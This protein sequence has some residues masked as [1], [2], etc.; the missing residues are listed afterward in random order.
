MV[1]QQYYNVA[2]CV[3]LAGADQEEDLVRCYFIRSDVRETAENIIKMYKDILQE[4]NN[5]GYSDPMGFI[6]DYFQGSYSEDIPLH[7]KKID[8]EKLSTLIGKETETS[9]TI[10]ISRNQGEHTKK[11]VIEIKKVKKSNFIETPKPKKQEFI[12]A[13]PGKILGAEETVGSPIEIPPDAKVRIS[14]TKKLLPYYRELSVKDRDADNRFDYFVIHSQ[15]NESGKVFY[16]SRG[17]L[18]EHPL[19][20]EIMGDFDVEFRRIMNGIYNRV[21]HQNK[22]KSR[23]Q[24]DLEILQEYFERKLGIAREE[25]NQ[26]KRLASAV[27]YLMKKLQIKLFETDEKAVIQALLFF[28]SQLYLFYSYYRR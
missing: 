5:H 2:Y 23:K 12:I 17:V 1:P 18:D 10:K 21:K 25:D 9:N 14:K 22:D 26:G 28:K 19:M 11:P 4:A 16:D 20:R 7:R 24:E 6:A 13:K 3:K 15:S 27:A 8:R